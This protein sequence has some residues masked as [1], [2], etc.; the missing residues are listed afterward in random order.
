MTD[1]AAPAP[2]ETFLQHLA[3]ERR[4]SP[5]TV[6]SYRRDLQRIERWCRDQGIVDWPQLDHQ[7]VRRYVAWRHRGGTSGRTLQRELSALRGLF[8][9]LLR[10][11]L[12]SHNPAVGVRTPKVAHKLPATLE[13]D[14][15]CALLDHPDDDPL[16]VRDTAMIEL[17]YSSGLRLAELVSLDL[18]TIDRGDGTLTVTGKGA[19][20]RTVPVGRK[21]CAA[22]ERWL[23]V[24]PTLAA[25]DEPALFVS[26][27]GR[28]IHPRTVQQRL[29]RWAQIEGA[30]RGVHPHLLRHSFATHLLESSG[31]LRA[32][33]EL[34]GHA[35][36]TTTQVYTHLDFQHLASVY[37]QAHPRAKKRR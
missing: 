12:A 31:D 14:Q 20:T 16:A 11:G 28:R 2:L 29:A 15:L 1:G 35:D 19:K 18:E 5:L 36:I 17:F 26:R 27:R 9:Y 23:A 37:D 7:A 22:L 3:H 4:A 13:A 32:V 24:R 8:R 33:Q 34:L 30:T 21:A 25:A 10:E 6:A